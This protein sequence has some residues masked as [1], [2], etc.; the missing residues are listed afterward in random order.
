MQMMYTRILR[1]VFDNMRQVEVDALDRRV[2]GDDHV[3]NSSG[4]TTN[5][6]YGC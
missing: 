5:I 4:A 1:S 3:H 6:N 2:L